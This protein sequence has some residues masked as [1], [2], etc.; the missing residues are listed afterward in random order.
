LQQYGWIAVHPSCTAI[1]L[2]HT[3]LLLL[4]VLLQLSSSSSLPCLLLLQA[5][6]HLPKQLPSQ[7]YAS[8]RGSSQ[9]ADPMQL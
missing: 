7:G 9:Q 4:L 1:R 5:L 3:Q 6:I 8:P 2:W